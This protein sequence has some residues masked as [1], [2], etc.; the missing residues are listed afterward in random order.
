MLVGEVGGCVREW[1]AGDNSVSG[2][3]RGYFCLAGGRYLV[4]RGYTVP[5]EG[6]RRAKTAVAL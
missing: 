4:L 3:S 1:E 2:E 5:R 6:M